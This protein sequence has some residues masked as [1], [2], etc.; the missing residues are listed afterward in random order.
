LISRIGKT[1]PPFLVTEFHLIGKVLHT[2]QVG[3]EG[4][5]PQE[6]IFFQLP[7]T[8]L[9]KLDDLVLSFFEDMY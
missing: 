8:P 5:L 6:A 2:W 1:V 4:G 9:E 7:Q 3:G